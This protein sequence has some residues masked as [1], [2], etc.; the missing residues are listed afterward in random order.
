M[1]MY[2]CWKRQ[3]IKFVY[4]IHWNL[5]LHHLLNK[6]FYAVNGCRQNKSSNIYHNN[7]QVLLQA[8]SFSLHKTLTDGLKSI[9]L[10]LWIIVMFLYFILSLILTASIQDP[11]VR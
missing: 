6:G 5:A 10:M 2:I 7:P 9:K 4:F 1:K 8:H 3:A 11:L